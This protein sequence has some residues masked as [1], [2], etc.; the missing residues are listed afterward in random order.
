MS[1][2]SSTKTGITSSAGW[3]RKVSIPI[4]MSQSLLQDID[5]ARG[6]IARSPF[7]CKILRA[8]VKDTGGSNSN[9]HNN[10]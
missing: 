8:N 6:D 9:A 10:G 5:R 1:K 7:V 3:D 2:K 4:S